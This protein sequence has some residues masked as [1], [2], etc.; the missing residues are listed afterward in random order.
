[1]NGLYFLAAA[2]YYA[3]R[4]KQYLF[5]MMITNIHNHKNSA[6]LT[7]LLLVCLLGSA[8]TRQHTY[9]APTIIGSNAVIDISSLNTATP[10]FL[11]YHY[12][13][14]RINFFIL[15]LDSGVQ[16]Y[17]DACASCY[18]HKQGYRPDEGLVTCRYCNMKFP[19]YKLEKG[20]GSCY[21]IK[22]AGKA[23]DGEYLISLAVLNGAAKMF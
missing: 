18:H 5:P 21:P 4:V 7:L 12:K 20:L 9:A 8:C 14:K 2:R 3:G 17:L 16:S 10:L 13:G 22:I 1:V 19:I 23:E 11:T 6:L 15:R